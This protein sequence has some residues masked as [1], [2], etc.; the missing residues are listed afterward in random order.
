MIPELV[1]GLRRDEPDEVDRH[2]ARC[3]GATAG[4]TRA[5]RSCPPCPTRS[6]LVRRQPVSRRRAPT[7]RCSPSRAAA[8]TTAASPSGCAYGTTACVCAPSES[9]YQY[10][11][12]AHR[13]T[14]RFAANGA[15][16]EVL[17]HL[18]RTGEQLAE[19]C[20]ARSRASTTSRSP[21]TSSTGRRPSPRTRTCSRCR[22]RTRA[23]CSAFVDTA[24]KCRAT[25][26]SSP[27]TPA[28]NQSRAERAFVSV[29]SVVNV[30]DDTMNS[31]SAASKPC[32]ASTQ[33]GAVDVGDEPEL[34]ARAGC[35]ARSASYAIAG[36]RSLPPI[37]MLTTFADRSAGVPAPRARSHRSA[38]GV[39]FAST[40]CTS[41]TTSTPS[42]TSD[43]SAR[44]AQRHVQ[45]RRGPR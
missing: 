9:R 20:R 11:E 7:C 23:P 14:G 24:T 27:P 36:P 17:V 4:S 34:H 40:R 19:V 39:I 41:A 31:V 22:C 29:S 25:A 16:A 13:C 8:S 5:G 1:P 6:A 12:Q 38:N 43:A 30:F 3:P 10:A 35:T 21:T 42:T 2:R 18:V 45:D 32:T 33:I 44:H 26:A 15:D 37:P 28:S